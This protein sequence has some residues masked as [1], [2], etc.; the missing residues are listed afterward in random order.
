[1]ESDIGEVLLGM[2]FLDGLLGFVEIEFECSPFLVGGIL[3]VPLS[4]ITCKY[5]GIVNVDE[6]SFDELVWC[7]RLS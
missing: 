7:G 1:M 4:G 5:V 2:G 6:S 3:V